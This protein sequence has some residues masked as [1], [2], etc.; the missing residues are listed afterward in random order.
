MTAQEKA[1]WFIA[2]PAALGRA[3]GYKDF[4]D[5]LHGGWI[6]RMVT[7]EDDMTL[8]AHRG[9]YKTTC[10]CVAIALLMLW[11]P[12]QNIIFLRKTDGDVAEVI[13]TVNRIL[14]TDIMR[15][16]YHALTGGELAIARDNS[17]EISL[18]IYAAPRGAAQLQGIGIGGSLTGK[19]ADIIITD[20]IVNLKDRVSRA[21]RE[22][23]KAVYMELQNICNPGGRFINTGTPWHKD[24]AFSIM[25]PAEKWDCYSIGLLT[26][27]QIADLKSRMTA[28][29]FAANYELRHI[30]DDD[31]IF[32]NPQL[33]ADTSLV[34]QGYSHVDAAYYGED[35]TA[36]TVINYHDGKFYVFG[37]CWRKHID[38]V[39]DTIIQ[40]H[41]DLKAG[42]M[43]IETNGDKGYVERAIRKKGLRVVGY[44]ESQNKYIKITSHLKGVWKDVVF[45]KGTDDEYIN[46]ITD[47][48]ENAEHD[49][50]PDSLA[51]II[52]EVGVRLS[53]KRPEDAIDYSRMSVQERI[54]RL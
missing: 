30:A 36:F 35:Y 39:Q 5:D 4:R 34:E 23:T 38:D 53:K 7:S 27:Q 19:H 44:T 22:R 20:D 6:K 33:G 18:N 45:V 3:L 37:K 31:V 2:H 51:S 43:Y 16:I 54:M 13:K 21:E 32:D 11:H 49:D 15:D 40:I 47:Y 52:R 24:D 29:L 41:N 48:N 9:S 12:D 46:Q 25:P 10:L 50:C 8:Q 42:K 28:S 14:S 26:K 1:R 17:S